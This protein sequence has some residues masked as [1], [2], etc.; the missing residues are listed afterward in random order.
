MATESFMKKT[1]FLIA[2]IVIVSAQV[3]AKDD[4]K[5]NSTSSI[6][7]PSNYQILLIGNSHSV[8]NGLPNLVATLI[9][10]GKAGTEAY[11]GAASG[12]KFLD[13]RLDDG[14]TLELL[15]SRSWTHVILQAQKYSSTG[16]YY[17]ST[18]AAEQWIRL[19]RK[20]NARPI[21]FPEWPR[22]GNKE[23]GQRIHDLHLSISSR[24][25]AC[26]APIGL[27]WEESIARNPTLRLHATDGNHSN[28]SGALLTA[29]VLYHVTTG[30]SAAELP[31]I[32]AIDVNADTQ[33][34]L[35]KVAAEVVLANQAGCADMN[36]AS[37]GGG[38]SEAVALSDPG[39]P[40]L[41]PWGLLV[42]I[43]GVAIIGIR[44]R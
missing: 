16:N 7:P 3:F 36:L 10:T 1:N 35:S 14:K 43:L 18:A 37:T 22:W 44:L 15:E 12:F 32:A 26:V 30:Q 6:D 5:T 40:T 33:R 24:E 27:A 17:Y 38:A 20:Q 28:L 8:Y 21:L 41:N 39:I 25:S 2:L 29:Y 23:E 13:E 19:V 9:E 34:Y 4:N 42:L 31:F 11:S